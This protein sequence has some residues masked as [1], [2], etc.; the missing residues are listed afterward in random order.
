LL[1]KIKVKQQLFKTFHIV[2]KSYSKLLV[3]ITREK[4]YAGFDFTE[5]ENTLWMNL[6]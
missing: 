6:Y 2:L 4:E 3:E 1:C 5:E